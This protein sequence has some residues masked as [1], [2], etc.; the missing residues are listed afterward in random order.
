MPC[1]MQYYRYSSKTVICNLFSLFCIH[2]YKY[3]NI[4]Q[5][6]KKKKHI[7]VGDVDLYVEDLNSLKAN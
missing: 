2:I 4:Y 1:H 3:T 5:N 6:T 7:S